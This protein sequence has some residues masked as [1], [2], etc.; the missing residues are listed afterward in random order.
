L[1]LRRLPDEALK[2][3]DRLSADFIHDSLFIGPKNYLVGRA[4]AM[5]GNREAARIAWESGLAVLDARLKVNPTDADL[6][7]MRGELLAWLG[8]TDD[9]L[10]EARIADEMRRSHLYSWAHSSVRIFAALGRADLAAPAI[11]K[12]LDSRVWDLAW[13]LTPTLLRQDPLWDKL[14]GDPQFDAMAA[15]SVLPDAR[16]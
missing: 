16:K 8:R 7:S 5:A 10:G 13:P 15:E 3:F 11:R 12:L 4:Q 6:H 9:A 2:A 1:I 14:R